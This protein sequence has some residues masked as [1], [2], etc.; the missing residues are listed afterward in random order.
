V[1]SNRHGGVAPTTRKRALGEKKKEKKKRLAPAGRGRSDDAPENGPTPNRKKPFS[2]SETGARPTLGPDPA[3]PGPAMNFK[4]RKRQHR[5]GPP[6]HSKISKLSDL[7]PSKKPPSNGPN[8]NASRYAVG[9]TLPQQV[10][11][12]GGAMG[13]FLQTQFAGGGKGFVFLFPRIKKHRR[14]LLTGKNR[15]ESPGA[16]RAGNDPPRLRNSER[17]ASIVQGFGLQPMHTAAG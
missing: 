17:N 12:L 6:R 14:L 3:Q 11:P 8:N 10:M 9:E 13:A 5:K 1:G 15:T 4:E 7:H 2:K 16:A